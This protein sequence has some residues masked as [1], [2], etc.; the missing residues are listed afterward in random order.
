MTLNAHKHKRGFADTPDPFC[1]VCGS[2]EDTQHFLLLCKSY[3]NLRTNLLNK[4]SSLLEINLTGASTIP[5]SGLVKILLY[6]K[7]DATPSLNKEILEEVSTFI[8]LTKRFEKRKTPT[9][10]V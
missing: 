2:Y 3:R 8:S 4:V 9:E 5:R 1:R 7:E 10:P 6:G